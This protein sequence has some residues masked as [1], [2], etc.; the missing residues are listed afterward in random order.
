MSYNLDLTDLDR[1]GGRSVTA[2][3]VERFRA[4]IDSGALAPGEKLPT[5][6]ALAEQASINHLTAVRVYRRLAE[7]GY[8]TAAVGR[9]TFVRSVPPADGERDPVDW[10][11][12]VLPELRPSY[13]NEIFLASY[14]LPSEPGIVS[15]ATGSPDPAIYPSAALGRIAA[16]VLAEGGGEP[17][18]YLDPD[19]LPELREEIA[20]RGRALGF[21]Q[22][23]DE[24]LVT[25]GARQAI[26]L[27]CR[28][29]VAPGDVVVCESPTFIGILSSLQFSGARV[30]G[31]PVDDE[32]LDVDALERIL[33]RHEVK[34]VAVQSGC[35]NPTGR[36][37][38]PA[39]AQRLLELARERSF[40]VLDDGVYATVRFDGRHRPRLRHELPDHVIYVDSLSKTIGG[41]LRIG[42]VAASGPV[43]Q[44][45]TWIKL[46]SDTHTSSLTQ[47]V[48]HR[49]LASGEHERLLDATNPGYAHRCDALLASVERHLG[50][51]VR[52]RRPVGG[53]HLWLTFRQ[54]IDERALLS[55]AIRCG[56][57]FLPGN[58]MLAEPSGTAAMRISFARL[59]VEELDEGVRRLA[60]AV[61][62][63]R[64]RASRPGLAA[65][66]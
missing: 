30:I 35:Q 45:L 42:W 53:H 34:L 19:G 32:G 55:E 25:S 33:A 12:A 57:T 39:R 48:A 6:R 29:V 46:H 13:S 66:S 17:L 49:W 41:G 16:E 15:L 59:A 11:S 36:D 58:A 52:V 40:F 2:Q 47:H 20:E 10:Q 28:S 3:L 7:Q 21:S 43:R 26:D 5:T 22:T 27:V 65:L 37:L 51:E 9:G 64:H 1:Q 50:D 60:K 44:R 18:S 38:S 63:V 62:A 4:A 8:V 14:M 61:R 23:A 54:P 24:I 56:V 31:V